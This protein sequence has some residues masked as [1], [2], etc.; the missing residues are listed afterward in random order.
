MDH[1][2]R[3]SLSNDPLHGYISFIGRAEPGETSER[4]VIDHPWL[5]RLRYIHQLQ[6]AWWVFP[7]AEHTRFQHV[8]GAMHLA[9]RATERLYDSLRTVCPD[10][11]SRAYVETLLRMAGLLHDVGHG[12]FGH[13]FDD[14]FLCDY[15]LTHE[16]L[17]CH[18][19]R[20]ELGDLLRG[21]RRNPHGSLEPGETLDPEQIAF[22]IARPRPAS[23]G[24]SDVG[25]S[26]F[27]VESPARWLVLLRSLFS[28]LYTVDNMDFVLRDAY[29][30]G[31]S[32]KAFDL[33]RLLHYTFFTEQGLTIHG[34]G[35]SALV[36]FIGVRAE[37]FRSIY[38]HR[39]VRAI[40]LTLQDLF[41]ESKGQLFPGSPLEHLADYQ[42]FTEASLL[43][44]VARWGS[45]NDPAKRALAPAWQRFLRREVRWKMACERTR[46][47]E[48]QDAERSS[49]F[50]RSEFVEQAL[51]DLLPSHLRELPLRVDLARHV[52]RPGTRGPTAGQNFLYD[53]SRG[54]T[55]EL[56][57]HELFRKIPLSYRI[58]RVYA[59][60][61]EHD[62]TLA[63]ALDS[64]I[65]TGSE[66]SLTNM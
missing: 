64:L 21:V 41:A 29:M 6:T 3:E 66:D 25:R 11:P 54:A 26:T 52:H 8:L 18:I 39:T 23:E 32:T 63:A 27:D 37:L 58:C 47:F 4:Q 57:D 59:E 60:T 62:V 19:I 24:D 17:G 35:L 46:F 30:S 45:S 16:T 7:A 22:L 20:H 50:S 34:R 36:R 38:F 42:P 15:G 48:P 53:P 40:D 51:R 44:D 65:G 56:S 49:I 10:V 28:G 33:E 2:E 13:F 1:F 14:H 43:V 5:Q 9:S 31:Y 55:R 61:H 12:P